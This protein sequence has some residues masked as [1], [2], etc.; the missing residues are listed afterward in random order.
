MKPVFYIECRTGCSCCSD[1]NHYR[2]FYKTREE[3]QA[4]VDRFKRGI[5]FPVCSQYSRYGNYDI[6]ESEAEEI[7]NNRIIVNDQVFPDKYIEIDIED[8]SLMSYDTPETID[9]Y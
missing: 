8:G 4:R 2:G 1:E 6:Y 7:S 9:L 5:D 3:A